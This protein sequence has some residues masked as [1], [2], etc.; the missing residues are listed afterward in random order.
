MTDTQKREDE[1]RLALDSMSRLL[2]KHDN[3][4]I[5]DGNNPYS[6]PGT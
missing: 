5:V 6:V 2:D 3:S 4:Q 1:A